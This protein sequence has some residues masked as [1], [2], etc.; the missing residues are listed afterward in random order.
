MSLQHIPGTCT[1]NIFMC[2]QMLW[3]CPCYMS[4]LHVPAT[5]VAS[6]CTKRIFVPATCRC[7]M[8]LQHYPSC[9]PT[10]RVQCTWWMFWFWGLYFFVFALFAR[11]R[12]KMA[13]APKWWRN[14]FVKWRHDPNILLTSD[15]RCSHFMNYYWVWELRKYIYRAHA[16]VWGLWI[17]SPTLRSVHRHQPS[18][19]S[20]ICHCV[21]TV[22]HLQELQRLRK[23]CLQVAKWL[24][25]SVAWRD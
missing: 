19:S 7:D 20:A 10:L 2:V 23:N 12:T 6:V 3:F 9:L 1:R 13:A 22:Y 25:V 16:V 4:P 5:S 21:W 15:F 11:W 14:S 17:Y 8:S 18:R 24:P